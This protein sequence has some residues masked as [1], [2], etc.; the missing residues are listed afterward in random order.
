MFVGLFIGSSEV[1]G[2]TACNEDSAEA[3]EYE[4]EVA[5]AA[6]SVNVRRVRE[7]ASILTAARSRILR[8]QREVPVGKERSPQRVDLRGRR[9]D[10]A[11]RQQPEMPR[12]NAESRVDRTWPAS[13]HRPAP[14]EILVGTDGSGVETRA[15]CVPLGATTWTK[16]Q[17][18]NTET[19]A[20][21]NT[22]MMQGLI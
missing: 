8:S 3:D 13:R 16:K 2:K 5:S 21:Y 22:R 9:T 15:F 7:E 11:A 14:A 12:Q 18:A 4:V 19:L 1:A 17:R 20:R 6:P 10:A